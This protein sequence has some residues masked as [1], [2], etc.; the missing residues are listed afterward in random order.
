VS[1]HMKSNGII[2]F[3]AETKNG[4]E[5]AVFKDPSYDWRRLCK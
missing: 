2:F 3:M 1:A 4:K 5:D